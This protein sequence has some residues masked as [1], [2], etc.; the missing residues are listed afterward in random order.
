MYLLP[1]NFPTREAKRQQGIFDL[2]STCPIRHA[3]GH[4]ITEWKKR[5]LFVVD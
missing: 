4:L 1:L 2:R 5:I 3:L